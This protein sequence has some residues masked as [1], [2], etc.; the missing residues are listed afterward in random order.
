MRF[1]NVMLRVEIAN[2]INSTSKSHHRNDWPPQPPLK[3]NQKQHPKGTAHQKQY[4]KQ[5]AGRSCRGR[6]HTDN[7]A[8]LA[9]Q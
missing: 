6:C 2:A 1:N 9:E 4:E 8:P 3:R 7:V 5:R